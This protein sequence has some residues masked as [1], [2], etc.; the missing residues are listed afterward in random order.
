EVRCSRVY[1]LLALRPSARRVP[2]VRPVPHLLPRD[3]AQGRAAGHRQVQL[4][5]TGGRRG[6][7][8]PRPRSARR[9]PS[10]L[11]SRSQLR[12]QSTHTT[13]HGTG[14]SGAVPTTTP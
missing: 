7:T 12:K 2:E 6:R 14:T 10:P 11:P 13:G 8:G 4:V 9:A 1:S 3:G 5:T